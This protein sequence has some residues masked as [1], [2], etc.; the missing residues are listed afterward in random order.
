MFQLCHKLNGVK[1]E[2][3]ELN[4]YLASY[5]Q[6]LHSAREKLDTVQTQMAYLP[7]QQSLID[8]EKLLLMAISKWS[9]VE[10][11]ALR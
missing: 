10:E 9:K 8:E 4:T 7:H 1:N 5:V 2:V 3:K 11:Q 6:K